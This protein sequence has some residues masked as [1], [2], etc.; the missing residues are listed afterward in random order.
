[1]PASR[2]QR[3]APVQPMVMRRLRLRCGDWS[4]RSLRVNRH[5]QPFD[6]LAPHRHG[7]SQL[8]L[9]LRG[10]G[11]QRIG[12]RSHSVGAGA[13]FFIPAGQLHEFREKAPRRAI[14]LV[15][16]LG[17]KGPRSLRNPHGW[18]SAEALATVRQRVAELGPEG[19]LDL[20]AGGTALL[21]VDAC[22]R[23]C[24]REAPAHSPGV[25]MNR[26]RRAWRPDDEGAWPQPAELAR[27]VGLQK[28]YLNRLVRRACG[29]TLGQWRARELLRSASDELRRGSTIAGAAAALGFGDASYFARWFRRQTGLAPS[30]WRGPKGPARNI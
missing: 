17:G 7:H 21:I 2:E 14:C 4:I 24:T 11:E 12:R 1:M 25:V 16:D 15:A 22:R 13:V 8:L 5:L 9:Y 28:D 26:L 10:H 19:E 30:Q 27:R 29:L 20:N 3:L 6:H 23:A 18:L